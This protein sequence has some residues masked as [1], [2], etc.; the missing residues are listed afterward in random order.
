MYASSMAVYYIILLADINTQHFL[1]NLYRAQICS[2]IGMTFKIILVNVQSLMEL[3]SEDIFHVQTSAILAED[4]LQRK[5]PKE[6][7]LY[8]ENFTSW[9]FTQIQLF[10][11]GLNEFKQADRSR[12][13]GTGENMYFMLKFE[14]IKNSQYFVR[15][16]YNVMNCVIE[17]TASTTWIEEKLTTRKLRCDTILGT[18]GR[19]NM[20]LHEKDFYVYT[21]NVNLS[22]DSSCA[23]AKKLNPFFYSKSEFSPVYN[24]FVSFFCRC[25]HI[26]RIEDSIDRSFLYDYYDTW[27]SSK[28][29]EEE[30]TYEKFI[31]N[32]QGFFKFI[33]SERNI[34]D[35]DMISLQHNG[36]T[37]S[38]LGGIYISPFSKSI[39]DEQNK[40]IVDGLLMDATWKTINCYVTSILMMSVCNVGIPIGF[41]FGP[42]ETKELYSMFYDAFEDVIHIDLKKY[43]IESDGG[44]A[45]TAITVEK[46]Q[47]Q[48]MC[49]HHYLR[50]L[51]TT[52]FSQQIGAITSCKCKIDLEILL[53]KYSEEFATYEND[54]E[55]FA[56]IQKTLATC[57]MHFNCASKKIEIF[58]EDQWKA[59][60]LIKRADYKM[61]TTTNALESSHGHLNARI[62]RR[63]DFYSSLSRLITFII[64]K[65]HNFNKAY[66]TNFHRAKRKITD[67]S[68]PFFNPQLEKESLQY[69]ST[70]ETCKCGETTIL[71]NMMR[72]N[73]PC[74]HMLHKGAKFPEEPEIEL[75]L[76]NCFHDFVIKY[77]EKQRE[78]SNKINDLNASIKNKAAATIR[79][80]TKCKNLKII[81]PTVKQF[82]ID[83]ETMFVSKMPLSFYSE[84]SNGIHKFHD[85]RKKKAS[86]TKSECTSSC[87]ESESQN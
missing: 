63:N 48:L 50:G 87:D 23:I 19:K 38:I 46:G 51:K 74:S 53:K 15:F 5:K 43:V 49:H 69:E 30:T 8:P 83:E 24:S 20:K 62:P 78:S 1:I 86:S 31:T 85:Y 68:S 76:E 41:S 39:C 72:T 75:F 3:P 13:Y 18:Q 17:V 56:L 7:H 12:T 2:T 33:I 26:P 45:L 40:G 25:K 84:V 66:S 28:Y 27:L 36:K 22:S 21:Y 10:L 14:H 35:K 79:K 77:E 55:K 82:N 9:N 61:P 44:S 71:N 70:R 64:D 57:G 54:E 6:L 73:L 11:N 80:F 58:N 65:T 81:T 16:S 34:S 59:V 42:G 32:N 60:S 52:E 37:Y 47:F 29:C 4:F 67:A